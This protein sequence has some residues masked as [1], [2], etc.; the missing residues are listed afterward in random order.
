MSRTAGRV[1]GRCGSATPP[2]VPLLRGAF[3]VGAHGVPEE[4]G[5]GLALMGMGGR[6]PGQRFKTP[7][8]GLEAGP[9][10]SAHGVDPATRPS[11]ENYRFLTTAV[12][13]APS[14]GSRPWTPT[15]S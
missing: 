12:H 10:P 15:A 2:F 13:P 7:P 5:K 4:V 11:K 6:R 14:P 3:A 8:Q 9:H 1:R